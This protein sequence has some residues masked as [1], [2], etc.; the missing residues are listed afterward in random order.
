MTMTSS[1]HDLDEIIAR[2]GFDWVITHLK[3]NRR[4]AAMCASAKGNAI[5]SRGYADEIRAL[6]EL[7]VIVKSDRAVAKQR[8]QA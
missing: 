8:R 3:D 6:H 2:E 5:A 1:I 7:Q 4:V